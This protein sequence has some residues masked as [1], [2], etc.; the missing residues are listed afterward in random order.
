MTAN[1]MLAFWVPLLLLPT[2]MSLFSSM[3]SVIHLIQPFYLDEFLMKADRFIHFGVD[4]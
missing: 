1:Y 2:F 3:K 4:P